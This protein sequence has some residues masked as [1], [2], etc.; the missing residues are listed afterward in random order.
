MWNTFRFVC[1]TRT[2][3]VPSKLLNHPAILGVHSTIGPRPT[4]SPIPQLH[5]ISFLCNEARTTFHPPPNPHHSHFPFSVSRGSR[6]TLI[7]APYPSL[8]SDPLPYP[9]A[10]RLPHE[11]YGSNWWLLLTIGTH[12]V[13]LGI[14]QLRPSPYLI[15]HFHVGAIRHILVVIVS[16]GFEGR[17]CRVYSA[18]R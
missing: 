16:R 9:G 17:D 3:H 13:H 4:S 8:I 5:P 7:R 11:T 10:G 1:H 15:K 6:M 18:Q 2:W 14:S 12:T